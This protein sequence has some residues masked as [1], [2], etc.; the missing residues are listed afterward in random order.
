MLK[1]VSHGK[2]PQ[3]ELTLRQISRTMTAT[4]PPVTPPPV[5]VVVTGTGLFQTRRTAQR[6]L[7]EHEGDDNATVET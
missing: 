7:F 4:V 5:P 3:K 2:A 1:T 6:G